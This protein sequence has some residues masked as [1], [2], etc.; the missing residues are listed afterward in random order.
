MSL[1]DFRPQAFATFRL[2]DTQVKQFFDDLKQR[3]LT[4]GENLSTIPIS[5]TPVQGSNIQ[6]EEGAD[7]GVRKKKKSSSKTR[8]KSSKHHKRED[9]TGKKK[10]YSIEKHVVNSKL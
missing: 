5:Q 3:K 7:L 4:K 6:T 8:S 2:K 10:K 9:R 1:E